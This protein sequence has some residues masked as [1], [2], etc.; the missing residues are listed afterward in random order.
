MAS[1]EEIDLTQT[2]TPQGPAPVRSRGRRSTIHERRE[3]MRGLLAGGLTL[4]FATLVIGA[5]VA[6]WTGV[7]LQTIKELLE[8]LL[9]PVVALTGSAMGFYFGGQSSSP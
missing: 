6:A 3:R 1:N 7:T 9:P 2:E 8:V 5:G 4:I